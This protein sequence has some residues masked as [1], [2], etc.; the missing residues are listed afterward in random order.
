M[1]T[2]KKANV[3]PGVDVMF[4]ALMKSGVIKPDVTL[5]QLMEAT[6][7]MHGVEPEWGFVYNNGHFFYWKK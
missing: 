3:R 5:K 4:D 7:P 1:S 2:E 6:K